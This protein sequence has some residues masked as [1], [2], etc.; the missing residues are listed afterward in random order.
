VFS[1]RKENDK[2]NLVEEDASL[3]EVEIDPHR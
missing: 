1:A 2:G 3:K